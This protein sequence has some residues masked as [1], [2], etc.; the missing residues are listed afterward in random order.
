MTIEVERVFLCAKKVIDVTLCWAPKTKVIKVASWFTKAQTIEIPNYCLEMM[1]VAENGLTHIKTWNCGDEDRL[2]KIQQ[3]I[4]K[5][6]KDQSNEYTNSIL[7]NAII[8]GGK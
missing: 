7:E 6:I 1:Y 8:G 5:Q 3:E 4:I 2:I